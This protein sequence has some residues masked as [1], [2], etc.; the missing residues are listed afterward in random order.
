MSTFNANKPRKV[1]MGCNFE[2]IDTQ[3]A[4]NPEKLANANTLYD[5]RCNF[6]STMNDFS[7]WNWYFNYLNHLFVLSNHKLDARPSYLLDLGYIPLLMFPTCCADKSQPLI[8]ILDSE[9][10]PY[11]KMPALSFLTNYWDPDQLDVWVSKMDMAKLL[12]CEPD[13]VR[14]EKVFKRLFLNER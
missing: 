8:E 12:N 6:V 5:K 13:Q 3:I 4:S 11:I 9:A 14:S 2:F 10:I 1:S 7:N